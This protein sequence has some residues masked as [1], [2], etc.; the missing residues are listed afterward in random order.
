M[1]LS[2]KN[3]LLGLIALAFFSLPGCITPDLDDNSEADY[4]PC[5][6]DFCQTWCEDN[7]CRAD[8]GLSAWGACTGECA[9]ESDGCACQDIGCDPTNCN[10]WCIYNEGAMN[11]VCVENECLCDFEPEPT[12]DSG[13]DS[14]EGDDAGQD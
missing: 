10:H 4:V 7:F 8:Y 9:Q 2:N 14:G 3:E 12:L 13:P 5:T 11:G 6:D 1:K